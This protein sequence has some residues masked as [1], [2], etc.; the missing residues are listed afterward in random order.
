V[1]VTVR[2]DDRSC[3]TPAFEAL[4]AVNVKVIGL[5]TVRLPELDAV[6]VKSG[7]VT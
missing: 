4:L 3:K 5:P 2:G 6:S 7:P 1:I